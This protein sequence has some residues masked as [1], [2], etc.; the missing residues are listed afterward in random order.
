MSSKPKVDPRLLGLGLVTGAVVGVWAGR[1]AQEWT[2]SQS[3]G[4]GLID[5]DRARSVA[6]G[7][8]RDAALTMGER[9]RLDR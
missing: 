7:M 4:D 9:E 3:S 2:A 6:I 8:N 1:R 5:W